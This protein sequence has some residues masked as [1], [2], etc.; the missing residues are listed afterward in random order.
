M[1]DNGLKLAYGDHELNL[2]SRVDLVT[3]KHV[4]KISCPACRGSIESMFSYNELIDNETPT[5]LAERS[6][7]FFKKRYPSSCPD[8]TAYVIHN[9]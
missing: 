9:S 7:Y 6:V 4:I 1:N 3:R 5:L 8:S 2:E